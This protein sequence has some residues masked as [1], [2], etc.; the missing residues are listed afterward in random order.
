MPHSSLSY[1]VGVAA[2]TMSSEVQ[3]FVDGEGVLNST[4]LIKT[5]NDAAL[6][7][8]DVLLLGT[9]FAF[10]HWLDELAGRELRRLPPG[11]LSL[12]HI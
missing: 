3:W 6:A 7:G 12:I 5:L 8:E 2:D 11:S 9:A 1:M 10:V 4:G